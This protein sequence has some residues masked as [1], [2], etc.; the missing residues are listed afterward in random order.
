MP[1]RATSTVLEIDINFSDEEPLH[2]QLYTAMKRGI[3]D[4]RLQPGTRLPSTRIIADDLRISRTTVLNDFDQLSA[5]GYLEGKVGSGTRVASYVPGTWP[6][7]R[8]D[9]GCVHRIPKPRSHSAH[10]FIPMP[11]SRSCERVRGPSDPYSPRQASSP[12][13][14]GR[15][16]RPGTGAELRAILST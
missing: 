4:G 12:W 1:K 16:W 13:R 15:G 3:L 11:I 7:K 10:S 14:V 9:L 5:E 6:N 8:S 2:R